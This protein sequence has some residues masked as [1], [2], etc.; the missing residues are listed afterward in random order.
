M[1]EDENQDE[2]E[3]DDNA[4]HQPLLPLPPPPMKS[5]LKRCPSPIKGHVTLG[6]CSQTLILCITITLTTTL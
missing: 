4:E 5:A 1:A 3:E 6:E 2:D